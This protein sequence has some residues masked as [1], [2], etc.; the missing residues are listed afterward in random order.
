MRLRATVRRIW[1]RLRGV[2]VA[3]P[4]QPQPTNDKVVALPVLTLPLPGH[5]ISLDFN[6]E[7]EALSITPSRKHVVGGVQEE[8]QPGDHPGDDEDGFDSSL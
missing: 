3:T 8:C 5:K 6:P 1:V 7:S 2:A 4:A